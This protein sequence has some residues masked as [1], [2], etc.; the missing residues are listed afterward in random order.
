MLSE[1]AGGFGA[2]VLS[3]VRTETFLS[4]AGISA[5][6]PP[7]SSSSTFLSWG[8]CCRY[9]VFGVPCS[10]VV[11]FS[12]PQTS[13]SKKRKVFQ[14]RWGGSGQVANVVSLGS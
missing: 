7:V 3:A 1:D 14:V 5:E 10:F 2:A 11:R 8:D 6:R 9:D 13:T 4:H 12:S